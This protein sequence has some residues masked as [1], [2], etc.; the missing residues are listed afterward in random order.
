M[1]RKKTRSN[2]MIWVLLEWYLLNLLNLLKHEK[3]V[4]H[5]WSSAV[6][7]DVYRQPPTNAGSTHWDEEN[8][9]IHMV[10]NLM[11]SFFLKSLFA[12]CHRRVG[13]VKW[14][15]PLHLTAPP[16]SS[17]GLSTFGIFS[18]S[19]VILQK[20][21]WRTRM[22]RFLRGLRTWTWTSC[23]VEKDNKGVWFF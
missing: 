12:S 1:Q 8:I 16:G 7:G 11:S 2:K 21:I 15:E 3:I 5:R 4:G 19:F 20:N 6:A 18:A 10:A 17:F 9:N 13:L 22:T 14:M 23:P